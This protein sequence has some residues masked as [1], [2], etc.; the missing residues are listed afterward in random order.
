[1]ALRWSQAT[2]QDFIDI[3]NHGQKHDR[4]PAAIKSDIEAIKTKATW[5]STRGEAGSPIDVAPEFHLT[6]ALKFKYLIYYR[7]LGPRTIRVLAVK[8]SNQERLTKDEL[9]ARI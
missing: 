1:M 8:S 6:Y 3:V 4:K 5:V 9:N 2:K 7:I